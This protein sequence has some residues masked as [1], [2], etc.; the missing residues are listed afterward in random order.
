MTN[1]STT[2]SK[3]ERQ[4][5]LELNQRL[6]QLEYGGAGKDPLKHATHGT[7]S[8]RTTRGLLLVALTAFVPGG[9]QSV[10]VNHRIRAVGVAG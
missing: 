5:R 4:I 6:R 10:T 8:Q 3:S 7:F 9:A 1:S 2:R